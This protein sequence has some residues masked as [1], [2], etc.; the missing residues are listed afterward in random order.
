MRGLGFFEMNSGRDSMSRPVA[1]SS[2]T[3]YV[4][5]SLRLSEESIK[6]R[7]TAFKRLAKRNGEVVAVVEVNPAM[8]KNFQK[9]VMKAE[10]EGFQIVPLSALAKRF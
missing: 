2:R 8:L 7:F 5:H 10:K 3:P 1:V 4:R 9:E 6:D